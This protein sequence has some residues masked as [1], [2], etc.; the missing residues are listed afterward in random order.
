MSG[1]QPLLPPALVLHALALPV[2]L[3]RDNKL[4]WGKAP[5]DKLVSNGCVTELRRAKFQV[6]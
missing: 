3:L 5:H 2:V 6:G 1:G 4:G